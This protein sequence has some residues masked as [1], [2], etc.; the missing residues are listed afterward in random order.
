MHRP[1]I[2]LQRKTIE[3]APG[4]TGNDKPE[5]LE[6]IKALSTYH[7]ANA[8]RTIHDKAVTHVFDSSSDTT[9]PVFPEFDRL[10]PQKTEFYQFGSIPFNEAIISD[11]Y[12]VQDEIFL[13]QGNLKRGTIDKEGDF[14]KRLFVIHGDQMTAGRCRAVKANS[15]ESTLDYDRRKW[16]IPMASW[17][18]IHLNLG[19]TILRTHWEPSEGSQ[20]P[21]NV[22]YDIDSWGAVCRK[23]KSMKYHQLRPILGKGFNS[24]ITALFYTEMRQHRLLPSTFTQDS[25][26]PTTLHESISNL[27]PKVFLQLVEKVR[28]KVFQSH[29]WEGKAPEDIDF[30]S[31]CRYLQEVQLYL[32]VNL[33]VKYGDIGL[34]RF[35]IDPLIVTFF[36]ANQLNY[37]WEMLHY[38]W[39]LTEVNDTVLQR[40][41]LASGLVNWLGRE[42]TWKPIDLMLEHL[43]GFV[44]NEM[45]CFKNSTHDAEVTLNRSCLT[46]PYLRVL[47]SMFEGYFGNIMSGSHSTSKGVQDMMIHSIKLFNDGWAH[48]QTPAILQSRGKPTDSPDIM[49]TGINMI[50]S[51]VQ[52]FNQRYLQKA[53][54]QLPPSLP[55]VIQDLQPGLVDA[56]GFIDIDE[57]VQEIGPDL[58]HI[59]E[60][61]YDG[62]GFEEIS[63]STIEA[64]MEY[65]DLSTQN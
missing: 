32:N 3:R 57:S 7:I 51:K 41:I 2:P 45:K 34:L 65:L 5:N 6:R 33:A 22:L 11:N 36:G 29:I 58:D 16:Y 55:S 39:H 50:S 25:D 35:L 15:S 4:L 23:K 12:Q 13:H 24:R 62:D 42:T 18:H 10:K 47:R 56:D 9:F 52:V 30:R 49:T 1:W 43:N 21:H 37:G 63:A 20:S 59:V 26:I 31:M 14:A 46:N 48:K 28:L 61:S 17:F 40:S 64:T 38:K 44:A 27:T 60:T 19:E 8:I 53:N 54:G